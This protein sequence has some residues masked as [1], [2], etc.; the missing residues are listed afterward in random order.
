M[1]QGFMSRMDTLEEERKSQKRYGNSK[2]VSSRI[3]RT[4]KYSIWN[5]FKNHNMK[6][7]D[8][9]MRGSRKIITDLNTNT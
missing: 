4:E 7:R 9:W 3:F 5:F 1:L 2:K 6:L 8:D